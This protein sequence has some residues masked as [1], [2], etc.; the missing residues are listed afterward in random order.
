MDVE[1]GST[2]RRRKSG[3]SSVHENEVTIKSL[4]T[5][6]LIDQRT[7]EIFLYKE[8]DRFD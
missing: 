3:G 7:Q 1:E 4:K 8:E 6:I 2:K 5:T